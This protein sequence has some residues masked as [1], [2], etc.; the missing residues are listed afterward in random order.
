MSAFIA[1]HFIEIFFGLISAGL[2]AFCRYIY[3]QMKMYQKLVENKDNEELVK[4]IEEHIAPIKDELNKLR[5]YIL[6]EE[7][8][9]K[10]N[11]DLILALRL[12]N[13]ESGMSKTFS[14]IA[15]YLLFLIFYILS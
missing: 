8:S 2:L 7:K 4:L 9:N 15:D 3:T 12:E 14:E 5:I 11:I 10:G 6:E 1:Q 13:D